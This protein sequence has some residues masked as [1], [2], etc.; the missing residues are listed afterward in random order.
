MQCRAA[1]R[2]VHNIL[3]G[4]A[5]PG[6]VHV[7][8]HR[9]LARKLVQV[10]VTQ[11]PDDRASVCKVGIYA[12]LDTLQQR[13]VKR[14]ES[15]SLPNQLVKFKMPISRHKGVRHHKLH[16]FRLGVGIDHLVVVSSRVEEVVEVVHLA[17]LKADA[18]IDH[19]PWKAVAVGLGQ[20]CAA[21]R[22]RAHRAS[23]NRFCQCP[24]NCGRWP[25]SRIGTFCRQVLIAAVLSAARGTAPRHHSP[26]CRL[27]SAP[28]SLL[29]LFRRCHRVNRCRS[30]LPGR[31]PPRGVPASGKTSFRA[32][33][34]ASRGDPPRAA[35]AAPH[36]PTGAKKARGPDRGTAQ[37][38]P[39][40]CTLSG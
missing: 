15:A 10:T 7:F 12:P 37:R 26:S 34:P 23:N 6:G 32:S 2:P 38:L 14:F 36:C 40:V 24:R 29:C 25:Q 31:S 35:A 19:L 17:H 18:V 30:F 16:C 22:T 28:G 1:R 13:V 21:H 27:R 8:R 20:N 11:P 33:T 39:Q 5:R 9:H 3:C 4:D